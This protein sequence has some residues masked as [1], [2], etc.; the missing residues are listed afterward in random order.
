MPFGWNKK[1]NHMRWFQLQV[2]ELPTISGALDFRWRWRGWPEMSLVLS[3]SKEL[4]NS[5]ELLNRSSSPAPMGVHLVFKMEFKEVTFSGEWGGDQN[6]VE[7]ELLGSKM[8]RWGLWTVGLEG[9][10]PVHGKK[11]AR[12]LNFINLCRASD[13]ITSY[14]PKLWIRL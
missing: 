3:Y 13:F 14:A 2:P 12:I 5:P 1:K 11:T 6:R 8:Q 10:R 9:E 7:K 4:D